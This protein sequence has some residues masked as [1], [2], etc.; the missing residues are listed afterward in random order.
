MEVKHETNMPDLDIEVTKGILTTLSL[1]SFTL[2]DYL[3]VTRDKFDVILSGD[4]YI[5]LMVLFNLKSGR[6]IAR[7]WNETLNAG[8]VE[9]S[10]QVVG[11]CRRHFDGVQPCI[12]QPVESG[13]EENVVKIPLPRKVSKNCH[14]VIRSSQSVEMLCCP[15]CIKVKSKG[16]MPEDGYEAH[17]YSVEL[18]GLNENDIQP[19]TTETSTETV[20]AK[21]GKEDDAVF[22]Q[23]PNIL[24]T[25]LDQR[26]E[27]LI[28]E[29]LILSSDQELNVKEICEVLVTK[30]PFLYDMSKKG[31]KNSIRYILAMKPHFEKVPGKD[32]YWRC[33]NK[34]ETG[35][36]YEFQCKQCDFV[37]NF[38]NGL[39]EHMGVEEH[40]Q[41]PAVDCP[42]C[43]NQFFMSGIV[44][45]FEKCIPKPKSKAKTSNT[46]VDCPWCD[47]VVR[48]YDLK[49][50]MSS[51]HRWGVFRCLECNHKANFAEDLVEHMEQESHTDSPY[52][53]CP[54][55]DD[56]LPM[57]GAEAH[58]KECISSKT[59]YFKNR[60]KA[61]K[62]H[63]CD[64]VL[65]GKE[66]YEQHIKTH[67]RAR[68]LT[69][70]EA[71][72]SLYYYCDKCDKRFTQ[73]YTLTDHMR[74]DHSDVELKCPMC[75][76]TFKKRTQ[77][78]KHKIM[79]HSSDT[80]YNC[81]FCGKRFRSEKGR[82]THERVHK[83]AEFQCRFCAKLLKSEE[84]L[85]AHERYHTG[86]KP[87]KCD[88]CG[89]GYVSTSS[90]RQ[91]IAG[92]HKIVGPRGGRAGW[93]NKQKE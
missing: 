20:D 82:I 54:S 80:K 27:K 53:I 60:L 23:R 18:V 3:V 1:T 85:E 31:W 12:G 9:N 19:P 73:R 13:E 63:T 11:V 21:K 75:H 30:Y 78:T 62:C 45:H 69:E 72:M 88:H 44:S 17:D 86:E 90:L 83:D 52:I 87:F 10:D 7:V 76:L 92:A 34:Q 91:H 40:T 15:E 42:K 67:L 65:R 22:N 81:Q 16:A 56:T 41:D 43:K 68:G 55:C 5:A 25:K 32:G 4:P 39:I 84:N 58:Y 26:Y 93:K 47:K 57:I 36:L 35:E 33:S 37:A 8:L 51:E 28:T 48:H 59:R 38:A 74:S 64:K 71:K 6:F 77:W 66:K 89:N 50:H 29:A 49:W 14:K 70:E 61:H 79:A 2:G 46:P 24:Y